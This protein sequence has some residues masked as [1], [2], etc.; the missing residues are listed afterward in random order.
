M[1]K[2]SWTVLKKSSF[3]A[4]LHVSKITLNTMRWDWEG[5]YKANDLA[6]CRGELVTP[7]LSVGISSGKLYILALPY[8]PILGGWLMGRRFDEEDDSDEDW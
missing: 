7:I 1:E 6:F 4:G 3:Q 5:L 8:G 2:Q